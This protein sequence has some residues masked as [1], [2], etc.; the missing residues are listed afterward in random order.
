LTRIWASRFARFTRSRRAIR[1]ITHIGFAYVGGFASIPLALRAL[2]AR[3]VK[4]YITNS[5]CCLIA[6][7]GRHIYSQCHRLENEPQRGGTYHAGVAPL[8]LKVDC[9]FAF[10]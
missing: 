1:Y 7:E 2:R 5:V 6:P 4:S 9:R 8:G 10:L 3:V